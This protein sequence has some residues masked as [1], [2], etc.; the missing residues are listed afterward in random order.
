MGTFLHFP[1]PPPPRANPAI[2]GWAT[3]RR[4]ACGL[5][6]LNCLKPKLLPPFQPRQSHQAPGSS[7]STCGPHSRSHKSLRQRHEH[8]RK[9]LAICAAVGGI[10]LRRV[11]ANFSSA[12]QGTVCFRSTHRSSTQASLL[13]SMLSKQRTHGKLTNRSR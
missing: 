12:Y 8:R 9:A 13:C 3:S 4:W 6:N 5:F 7:F 10:I 1:V 11:H 2:W